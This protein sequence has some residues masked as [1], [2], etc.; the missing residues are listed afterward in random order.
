MVR[1]PSAAALLAAATISA[2]ALSSCGGGP[3]L[4]DWPAPPEPTLGLP[5]GAVLGNTDLDPQPGDSGGAPWGS[6]R[7]DDATADERVP[8]IVGRGRLIVG[9]SQSTNGLGYR[10]PVTGDMAGFEVDIAHEIARDIFGDP[11]R[12]DFRYIDGGDRE[13]ALRDGDVDIVVRTM[14]VTRARQANVEFSTPYLRTSPRLL[15]PRDS[16]VTGLGD[17]ADRT[18][19]VTRGST[20]AQEVYAAVPHR[21]VLATRTWPDCLM[22]MQRGQADATYSDAAILSGLQAQDPNTELVSPGGTGGTGESVDYAV[23]TA[24]ETVRDTAP[25][26]RQVNSTL[27]R[28]RTDGT[29]DRLYTRWLA[30]YLG[31]DTPPD[32]AY[33]DDRGSADLDRY[34]REAAATAAPS[35]S[36]APTTEARPR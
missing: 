31:P 13:S 28:L 27:E 9:V 32:A 18:V 17:L 14:T 22:A 24:P 12:V 33:R 16:G 6:L 23:A 2:L 35:T 30:P 20:N 10:D 11:G 5:D 3:D 4:Q 26:V 8:D 19:C 36:S 25:L 7:P 15:V 34:R 1:L 21:Q 29:W